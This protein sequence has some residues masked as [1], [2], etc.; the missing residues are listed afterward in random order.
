MLNV[1]TICVMQFKTHTLPFIVTSQ[2]RPQRF[3]YELLEAARHILSPF[4]IRNQVDCRQKYRLFV[5]QLYHVCFC[6]I[7][8]LPLSPSPTQ[9]YKEVTWSYRGADKSL[10]RPARKQANVSVRMAP[11]SFGAL[12]CRGEKPDDTARVSML[13]KSRATLTCFRACFHPGRA[14]DISAPR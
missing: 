8:R 9:S 10:A 11:I 1:C 12:P 2:H 14:K 3:P 5:V 6:S 7:G 4:F 13:L